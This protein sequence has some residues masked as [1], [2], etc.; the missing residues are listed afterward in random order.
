M[1][2]KIEVN[3]SN[4][5]ESTLCLVFGVITYLLNRYMPLL[6]VAFI[7]LYSFGY[8]TWEPYF[9]IGFMMF[10]NTFNFKCGYVHSELDKTN[11]EE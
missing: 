9:I 7:S 4:D 10:S 2:E 5:S 11:W 1:N 3:E 6:C 8:A